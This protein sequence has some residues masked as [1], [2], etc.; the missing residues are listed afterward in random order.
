MRNRD[1]W[2]ATRKAVDILWACGMLR[3]YVGK[4]NADGTFRASV[5]FHF[6]KAGKLDCL[7]SHSGCDHC[8]HL[9]HNEVCISAM[10]Q[11]YKH[12]HENPKAFIPDGGK[13]IEEL[14]T[15]LRIE[16]PAAP[17]KKAKSAAAG[18]K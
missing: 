17:Q 15:L 6:N 11:E 10:K 13:R 9:P 3:D 2:R 14:R 5:E 18:R 7:T 4:V 8:H 1:I 16:G 12:R